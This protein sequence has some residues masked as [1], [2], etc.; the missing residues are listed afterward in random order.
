M[1]RALWLCLCAAPLALAQDALT[2]AEAEAIAVKNHPQVSAALLNAAAANQVTTEVR[3]A[4]F[5]TVF[6]S[7][8]GAGALSGSRIAAGALNNPIIYNRLAAGITV[9]QLVTD[10]GRT[11]NLAESSRLR[12]RLRRKR[13]KRL[14]PTCCC[15]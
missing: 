6:G 11:S 4:F 15:R 3:S 7:V 14:R 8:T 10:F 9:S 5:P 12:A 1:R 13:R 2:L